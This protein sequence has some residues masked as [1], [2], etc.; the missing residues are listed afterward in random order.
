MSSGLLALLDDVVALAKLAAVTLDDVGL[1]TAKA[2]AKSAGVV[3]DD[4]AVTPKYVVGFSADRE[5]PIVYKIA[6]GSLRNKLLYLL[7]AAIGLSAF[8]PWAVTPLLMLGGTFLCYEGAEKIIEAVSGSS[9]GDA[10][11]SPPA[12]DHAAEEMQPDAAADL[13]QLEDEKVAGAIR[14]DFIL[15]A[16]IM[17]IAL[18]TLTTDS[19]FM[20]AVVLAAVGVGITL[21]VY[22]AVAIIVKADDVGMALAQVSPEK[23]TAGPVRAF[24]RG[25]VGFMPYFLKMLTI[26]GT[27]AMLWVGGGIIMHGIA[28]Y[29][30]QG[31][32]HIVHD[33]AVASASL[34]AS[35][36]EA[37]TWFMGAL[38]AA[39]F[40]VAIG[41]V[42]W[43]LLHF[44][45]QPIW[46]KAR[47]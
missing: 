5:L 37:V 15:S 39:V 2:G 44:V 38:G 8:A 43:A 14:T 47:S 18:A 9:H 4:A 42:V 45:V 33:I 22:G 27:A 24:G 32:E 12:I 40:G 25:M 20:Q 13:R 16:E 21:A 28:G 10:E 41:V 3:V 19:Y 11:Q 46:R 7:P 31:V 36:Q 17:A 29:G 23:R 35:L 1:Q 30:F 34:V 6:V 26:V